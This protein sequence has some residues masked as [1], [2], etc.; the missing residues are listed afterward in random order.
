MVNR[1]LDATTLELKNTCT[2]YAPAT[3]PLTLGDHTSEPTFSTFDAST[4]GTADA[5]DA[6]N[7]DTVGALPEKAHVATS[8]ANWHAS[9]LAFSGA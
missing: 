3:S 7:T 1:L 4:S 2:R 8:E 9:V 5:F 6:R